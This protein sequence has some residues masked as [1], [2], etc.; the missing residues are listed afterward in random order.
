M[1]KTTD[2]C[3]IIAKESHKIAAKLLPPDDYANLNLP[4]QHIERWMQEKECEWLIENTDDCK[5]VLDLG[6]G[7][8]LT[9]KAFSTYGK[10]VTM[11]DGSLELCA[12]ASTMP[13]V[14]PVHSMFEDYIPTHKY[15]CVI[16]SFILEH[17]ADPVGLLKRIRGW[18]DKLIVVVG[19]ANSYH[20]QIAVKMGL[21]AHLDD[22]SA[23]DVT[24]GHV[25]VYSRDTIYEDL[26]A[27]G[28][29][30]SIERGL[31]FKPL[32]NAALAKLAPNIA[33]TMMQMECSPDV[34]A[35]LFIVAR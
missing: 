9:C 22:L 23:R 17:I 20:R 10:Q 14:K 11:V 7:D 21:Q 3:D 6:F 26:L 25:R 8:G 31:G 30:P 5:R 24:V 34:A 2:I 15:D 33:K 18:T 27:A 4:D 13:F 1:S 19:N 32:H 35:N 28:W 16:A 12:E 29:V